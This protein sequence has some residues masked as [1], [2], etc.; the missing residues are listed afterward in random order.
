MNTMID[1]IEELAATLDN[2]ASQSI[3]LLDDSVPLDDSVRVDDDIALALRPDDLI[4]RDYERDHSD[5][6]D[7]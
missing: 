6:P 3:A 5:V 1:Q 7:F 2:V 4:P